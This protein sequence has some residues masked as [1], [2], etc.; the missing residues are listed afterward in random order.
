MQLNKKK[1]F[2]LIEIV[3]VL[4]IIGILLSI[5]VPRLSKTRGKA[6]IIA[7]NANVEMIKNAAVLYLSDNNE[8]KEDI[9]EEVKMMLEDSK[10]P[11]IPASAESDTWSVKVDK[12]GGIIV[13]PEAIK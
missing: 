1:G 2:T 3:V 9:T 12:E 10:Y 7:H 5:A 13:S 4:A 6:E 8:Y 11:S